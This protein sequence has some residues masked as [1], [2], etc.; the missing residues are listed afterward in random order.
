MKLYKFLAI[1]FAAFAVTACSDDKDEWNTESDAVVEMGLIEQADG[2][3]K[4]FYSTKEGQGL[5][6]LPIDIKG[7]R[8]GNVEITFTVKT[9]YENPA[10]DE[11]NILM[12]THT[13]V[14]FP[15]DD[16]YDLELYIVDDDE[17]NEPRWCDV[18]I[19]SVKGASIGANNFTAV[20]IRDNDTEPYD[21]CAG[22][23]ALI[24]AKQNDAG[25]F[26]ES[27]QYIRLVPYDELSEKYK[28]QYRVTGLGG[29]GCILLAYY[30][31]DEATKTGT[32]TFNYNQ[33][34][35]TAASG[36]TT[37]NLTFLELYQ[38]D[39]GLYI[40]ID[41][42]TVFNFSAEQQKITSMTVNPSDLTGTYP[43][44]AFVVMSEGL[45]FDQFHVTGMSR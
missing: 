3:Y 38:Q 17:M 31:Y 45:V 5:V 15:E 21:R 9:D 13:I 30:D 10:T 35:G 6:T 25:D 8:N 4:N 7:K 11:N 39:G 19:E 32:V 43:W 36:E 22:E 20:Q 18:T 34:G 16:T 44:W 42:G 29:E 14:V 27:R 28:H 41:G 2:S 37:Y 12:T 40:N 24:T 33:G 1:A 26:V 23:W